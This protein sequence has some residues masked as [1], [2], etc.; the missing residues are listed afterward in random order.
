MVGLE[1]LGRLCIQI[2]GTLFYVLG[3]TPEAKV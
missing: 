2:K 3:F 1:T